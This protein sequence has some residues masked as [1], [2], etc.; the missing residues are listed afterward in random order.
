[1][2]RLNRMPPRAPLLH[3]IEQ[4]YRRGR[5]FVRQHASVGP[6]VSAADKGH[7]VLV[8]PTGD[9]GV[10]HYLPWDRAEA[11]HWASSHATNLSVL[12]RRAA[13]R[14]CV[15]RKLCSSTPSYGENPFCAGDRILFASH[16]SESFLA[17]HFVNNL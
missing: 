13:S 9:E 7:K 5:A 8:S 3:S 14:C 15:R 2:E 17:R 6:L 10:N 12:Q 11:A 1:M 4:P 16:H